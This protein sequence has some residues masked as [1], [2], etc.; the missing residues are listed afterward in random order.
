MPAPTPA[1]RRAA[2][3]R[4][5]EAS[6]TYGAITNSVRPYE[7]ELLLDEGRIDEAEV[8]AAV[9]VR[10][11]GAVRDRDRT[12]SSTP[13]IVSAEDDEELATS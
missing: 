2:D 10:N 4:S 7:S 1:E 9:R 12:A 8:G 5:G 6:V 13:M 3:D 11:D